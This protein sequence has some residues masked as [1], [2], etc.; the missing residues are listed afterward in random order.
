MQWYK[1]AA[2]QGHAEALTMVGHFYAYGRGVSQNDEEA[3]KYYKKAAKQNDMHAQ[4]ALGEMYA[5]REETFHDASKAIKWYT[6]S[7]EQGNTRALA[8]LGDMYH[9]GR[10]GVRDDVRAYAFW[11]VASGIYK[12]VKHHLSPKMIKL[13]KSMTP[14]QL[15]EGYIQAEALVKKISNSKSAFSQINI[16]LTR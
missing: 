11:T 4:F 8:I 16:K 14:Q 6:I 5:K 1:K 10:G 13:K 2:D 3:V 9:A 15:E 12:P 7:A